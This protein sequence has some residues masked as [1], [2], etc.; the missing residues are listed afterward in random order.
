MLIDLSVDLNEKTPIYPGD[1][2]TK[3]KAAGVLEKDGYQDHYVCVGTHVGTHMDAPSHMVVGGKN[4][5]QFPL[6]QFSG[7]GVY[8][9]TGRDFSL[10]EISKVPIEAGDIVLFHTG[11]SDVYHQESY[12]DDYPA[13]PE[14][15]AN[16]LVEKKVKI[17]GVDMCSVDHPP[18]PV[19]Q[20]LLSNNILI[21][22]NLTNLDTLAGKS[23]K[24]HAFPVKLQLDGAPV[25]V[26]ADVE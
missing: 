17:V 23:F 25:R 19:H 22:E 10:T 24:I 21:I 13:M 9:R 3:I 26:V 15:V 11:M 8:I 18:F 20:I 5:D 4:L 12:Y 7:K 2:G 14:Q 16:Y 6:D 1:P